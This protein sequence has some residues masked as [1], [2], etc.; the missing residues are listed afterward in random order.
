MS[1]PGTRS[2]ARTTDR[3]GC[4]PIRAEGVAV[5]DAGRLKGTVGVLRGPRANVF[6]DFT[7]GVGA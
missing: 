6:W 3:K 2:D 4:Q 5:P 7:P 1:G